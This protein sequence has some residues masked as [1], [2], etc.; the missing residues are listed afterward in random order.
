MSKLPKP[1][2]ASELG[3]GTA[4]TVSTVIPCKPNSVPATESEAIENVIPVPAAITVSA[5]KGSEKNII[6]SVRE[7][8]GRRIPVNDD[9]CKF[10]S[11]KQEEVKL[12]HDHVGIE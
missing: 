4:E 12:R 2:I 9:L 7:S 11:I 10:T 5:P 6:R 3:S 8:K 1:I